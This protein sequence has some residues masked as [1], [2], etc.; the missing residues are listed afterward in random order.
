MP[1]GLGR[2]SEVIF[3]SS[4]TGRRIFKAFGSLSLSAWASVEE[5]LPFVSRSKA[6]RL[7]S[8]LRIG[9]VALKESVSRSPSTMLASSRI[10][11]L[12]ASRPR[13]G[14]PDP[15]RVADDPSIADRVAA[16]RQQSLIAQAALELT[17]YLQAIGHVQQTRGAWLPF[18]QADKRS[19]LGGGNFTK[20]ARGAGVLSCTGRAG[21]GIAAVRGID[22]GASAG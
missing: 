8:S 20:A 18:G 4:E 16:L 1:P 21:C 13:G 3:N 11:P 19:P 15:R 14:D 5:L 17:N 10:D 7:V 9:A 22:T 6:L 12:R 2:S